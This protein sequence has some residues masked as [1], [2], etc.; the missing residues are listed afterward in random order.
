MSVTVLYGDHVT[1]SSNQIGNYLKTSYNRVTGYTKIDN[2]PA[3]GTSAGDYALQVRGYH[4]DTSG[5]F[6]GVDCEADLYTTGTGSIRGVA[7]VAKVRNGITA[8][9]STLIGTY[10]QARVDTGGVL[11][12]NSFLV[13][14][15]GL[16]EASPAI[17]ANHV[18]SLWLDTHQANTVTGEYSLLYGSENGAEALDQVMYFR[19]PAAEK[20]IEFNTCTE[21]ISETAETGGSSKKIKISIDG[22]VH[23]INVYTG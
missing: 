3:S 2:R 18:C 8:T 13:G 5:N 19:T 21:F 11:A 12:G 6:T 15:Y 4:R 14:L 20:F 7:G 1:G 17:T 23:Y 10:G 9:D 22:T 16:I